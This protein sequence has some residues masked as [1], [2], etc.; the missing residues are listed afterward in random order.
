MNEEDTAPSEAADSSLP[1]RRL[2]TEIELAERVE[3]ITPFAEA[4]DVINLI[5]L[6]EGAQRR[7]R[8]MKKKAEAALIPLLEARGPRGVTLGH[9]RYYV[10]EKKT[11]RATSNHAVAEA[12]LRAAEGDV[13]RFVQ[14]LAS[15]AFK[16][17][18][19]RKL[20]GDEEW[21]KVFTVEIEKE[22]REGK[23]GPA[24]VPVRVVHVIDERFVK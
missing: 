18:E 13:D 17:G 1:E 4:E 11:V 23:A 10:G 12:V 16:P 24:E 20:I 3:N 21:G 6:I 7:L 22:V 14:C 15:G 19:T 5:G 9:L 8:D 2:V